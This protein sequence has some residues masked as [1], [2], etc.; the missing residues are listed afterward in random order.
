MYYFLNIENLVMLIIILAS[1]FIGWQARK[2]NEKAQK[3][4]N[5]IVGIAVFVRKYFILIFG[6]LLFAGS[7]YYGKYM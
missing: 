4:A 3:T 7:W 5:A 1:F 6:A 2:G